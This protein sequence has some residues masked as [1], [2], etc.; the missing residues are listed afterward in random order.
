MMGIRIIPC[1]KK[2][3]GQA[4]ATLSAMFVIFRQLLLTIVLPHDHI[5]YVLRSIGRP[6]LNIRSISTNVIMALIVSGSNAEGS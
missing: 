6:D 3:A 1:E 2:D 5:T 4:A